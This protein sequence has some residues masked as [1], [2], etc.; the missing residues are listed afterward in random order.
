ML[1]VNTLLLPFGYGL[2]PL[3]PPHAHAPPAGAAVGARAARGP[4]EQVLRDR[5][6]LDGGEV[7][8][9]GEVGRAAGVRRHIRRIAGHRG[10]DDLLARRGRAGAHADARLVGVAALILVLAVDVGVLHDAVVLAPDPAHAPDRLDTR[11]HE[12][13]L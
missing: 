4:Q 2:L 5:V 1:S 10:V 13:A 8:V 11:R 7:A 9:A 3:E 6:V 12:V